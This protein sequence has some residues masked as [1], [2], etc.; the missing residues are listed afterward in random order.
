MDSGET[1]K[2]T[3]EDATG[4]GHEVLAEEAAQEEV[5]P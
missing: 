2:V 4:K 1:F 5:R 3:I